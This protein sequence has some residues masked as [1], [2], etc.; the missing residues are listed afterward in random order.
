VASAQQ[1]APEPQAQA[2]PPSTPVRNLPGNEKLARGTPSGSAE[3]GAKGAAQG[4]A[5]GSPDGS[6]AV[7]AASQLYLEKVRNAIRQE[8]K[9]PDQNFSNLEAKILFVINREGQIL[10]FQIEK[11]AGNSLFDSAAVRA[12]Q[13]ANLPPMPQAMEGQKAEIRI[14]FS[15]QGV[16]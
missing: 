3:G 7:S 10:S 6:G 9:L 4:S 14:R 1:A 13:N 2:A 8:F 16:S 15:P 11:S 5:F 12:V